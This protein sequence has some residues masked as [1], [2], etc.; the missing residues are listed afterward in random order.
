MATVEKIE[1]IDFVHDDG[2][3]TKPSEQTTSSRESEAV[4]DD[5][6]RVLRGHEICSWKIL[7]RAHENVNREVILSSLCD[8]WQQQLSA[9]W[10][11]INGNIRSR[12][13]KSLSG[14]LNS[15]D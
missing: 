14:L 6:K 5:G 13:A 1:K 7:Q 4:I 12:V 2:T 8:H 10:T 15:T 9:D 3:S 11:S